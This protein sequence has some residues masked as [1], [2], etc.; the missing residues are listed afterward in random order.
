LGIAVALALLGAPLRAEAAPALTEPF[1][2]GVRVRLVQADEARRF[3][4]EH[5]AFVNALGEGDLLVRFGAREADYAARAAAA[6]QSWSDAEIDLVEKAVAL[7]RAR[8]EALGVALPLPEEVLLIKT[9]G[10]EEG[11]AGGYTRRN[12]VILT[13]RDLPGPPESLVGLIAHELF[14]VASRNR[15]AIRDAIYGIIGFSP[16]TALVFPASLANRRVTNPDAF[17]FDH[18]IAIPHDGAEL[19]VTPV[20]LLKEGAVVSASGTLLQALDVRLLAEGPDGTA[21]KGPDGGPLLLPITDAGYRSRI[22]AN[23]GYII[24]PEE[25]AADN[26]SLLV[27]GVEG[28][29]NPEI[30]EGIRKTLAVK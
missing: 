28:L 20:I 10:A 23:T 14:H 9:S 2:P 12:A 11:N 22:G 13:A 8:F 26:F 27:R 4:G 19:K 29:P 15:P 16:C 30:L 1:T 5:D 21:V 18:C 3:L 25:I 6:A 17:N 7:T 24:H